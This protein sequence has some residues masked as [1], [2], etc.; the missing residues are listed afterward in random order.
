MPD[1]LLG[2]QAVR[3]G[4]IRVRTVGSVALRGHSFFVDH[5]FIFQPTCS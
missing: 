1:S 2:N 3:F 4:Y 5:I